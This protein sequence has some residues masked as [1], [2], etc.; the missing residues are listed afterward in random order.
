MLPDSAFAN[1]SSGNGRM[2]LVFTDGPAHEF[3]LP[4]SMLITLNKKGIKR[5]TERN[6]Y[7]SEV[8]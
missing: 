4:V 6:Y 1:A 7:S 5:K 3:C 2:K 8:E